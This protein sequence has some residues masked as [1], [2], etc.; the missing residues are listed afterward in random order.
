M[1]KTAAGML[2]S[3]HLCASLGIDSV[4]A[5]DRFGTPA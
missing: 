2:A 5:H 3:R 4:E 1:I